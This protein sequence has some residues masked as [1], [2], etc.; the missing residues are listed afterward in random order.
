MNGYVALGIGIAFIAWSG[1]MYYEGTSKETAVCGQADAKHDLAQTDVTIK[2]K[3]GVIATVAKQQS[4]TQGVDNAYEAKKSAIDSQYAADN[5]VR[6]GQKPIAGAGVRAVPNPSGRPHAAPA[7]SLH[8]KVYKLSPQ[9]CDDNTNQL[10]GL[11][12]WVK[13][14]E[15]IP[16]PE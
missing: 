3:D 4:A 1:F 7:R 6:G 14:Q 5:S 8:T 16:P 13:A 15:A 10:Y 12:N 9:E 11:Q 2:A